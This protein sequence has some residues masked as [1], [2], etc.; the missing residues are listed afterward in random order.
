PKPVAYEI[1]NVQAPIQIA[2]ANLDKGEFILRNRHQSADAPPYRLFCEV[3]ED[4]V[5]VAAEEIPFPACPPMSE[6]RFSVELARLLS[7]KKAGCE[8]HLNFYVRLRTATPWAEAG[9][10]IHRAQI[11][12]PPLAAA[13]PI[14]EKPAPAALV[15]SGDEIA[16][17]GA[18]GFEIAFARQSGLLKRAARKKDLYLLA[19]G[20]ENLWRPQSGLD[21]DPHW[22]FYDLW[23]ALAPDR[24]S[25]QLRSISAFSL[26][27][28]RARVEVVSR[29]T[30]RTSPFAVNSRIAYIIAG[31]GH[32]RLEAEIDIERGFGHVP[33][34]GLALVVAPGFEDLEW[35]GRG[36]GESYIDRK[37]HTLVGRYRAKVADQH[38][39][40]V[41]P[42]ECGGHED[43]RWLRLQT[44]RGNAIEVRS[45][46]L[47]HFDARH[48]SLLDYWQAQHD[49]ELPRRPEVYL[50]L[51]CRHA[52]IGGNM[53]WSTA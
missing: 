2:V 18:D 41:P 31:D 4:G 7:R 25:R 33:R 45:A 42:A 32:L 1:K 9:H 12:L 22:G 44:P 6:A 35:F 38:F 11:P 24:I 19:G 27:D 16:V 36:P 40:F 48:S 49:H 46:A 23:S 28:G 51:D 37:Q 10:E 43:T 26:P 8:Y 3:C 30:S 34:V 15:E 14:C 39:P 50:H 20:A 21:T 17:R 52:G 13:E 47:F 5:A 53:G 29:L